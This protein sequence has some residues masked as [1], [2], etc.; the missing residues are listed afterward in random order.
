M[1]IDAL[2]FRVVAVSIVSLLKIIIC[3]RSGKF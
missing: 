3:F 1:L 2:N